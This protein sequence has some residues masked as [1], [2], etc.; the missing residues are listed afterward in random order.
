MYLTHTRLDII[1]EVSIVSRFMPKPTKQHAGAAKRILC[2]VHGTSHYGIWYSH[3]TNFNLS[4]FCD[5]GWVGSLDDRKSTTGFLFT[6]GSRA[7]T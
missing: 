4:G 7:I 2:Y 3:A 1:F 5:R 6:L